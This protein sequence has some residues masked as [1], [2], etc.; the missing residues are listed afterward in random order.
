MFK[1]LWDCLVVLE[2]GSVVGVTVGP[3]TVSRNL[4]TVLSRLEKL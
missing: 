1:Y 2:V 4:T 3:T